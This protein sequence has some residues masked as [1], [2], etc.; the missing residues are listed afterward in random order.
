MLARSQLRVLIAHET[1]KSPFDPSVI[2]EA[3]RRVARQLNVNT[4]TPQ[5]PPDPLPLVITA[6]Q[7]IHREGRYG[8]RKVFIA[9]LWDHVGGAIAMSLPEFKHWLIEQHRRQR[10]ELVR[11]DLISAMPFELVKRSE[12][13]TQGATFNFVLDPSI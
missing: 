9:A 12:T 4:R 8:D 5:T 10:L 2:L 13:K 3:K 11:A 6:L 1:G 7:T